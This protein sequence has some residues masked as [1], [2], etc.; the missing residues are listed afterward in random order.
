MTGHIRQRGAH[1]YELKFDAG[2]DPTTGKRLTKYHSFKGSKRDAQAKLTELLAQ[3]AKG[4][5][6][7][8]SKVTVAEHVAARIAQ[9]QAAGVI[10]GRTAERYD[11]LLANQIAPHIGN[12]AVQKLK[13]ADIESWHSV[14]RV[15]GRKDQTGGVSSLTIKHCHAL[16][17]KALKDGARHD[18][19]AR[20]VAAD[21]GTPKV[22]T[23]E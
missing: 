4:S 16:L 17:A 10:S 20:N 1:T 6:V 8:A 7:D 18:L 3:H 12:K 21:Q 15:A 11:E 2:T 13:V 19:V 5:F 23:D 9:W 22:E 14:L